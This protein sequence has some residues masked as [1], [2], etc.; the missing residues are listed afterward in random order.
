MCM[1][2]PPWEPYPE[3][4]RRLEQRA[5]RPKN[6]H[7]QVGENNVNTASRHGSRNPAT[8]SSLSSPSSA[9]SASTRAS[10]DLLPRPHRAKGHQRHSNGPISTTDR[11]SQQ[12]CRHS[13]SSE[14]YHVHARVRPEECKC[15]EE[16]GCGDEDGC[17]VEDLPS[18]TECP[19]H[20]KNT[21]ADIV[22][23]GDDHHVYIRV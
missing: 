11:D 20:R 3:R 16:G 18:A 8:D 17:C 14:S 6:K 23:V 1:A 12:H 4:K 9:S 13:G 10:A 22:W 7:R 21:P 2:N 15:L 5:Q 19:C